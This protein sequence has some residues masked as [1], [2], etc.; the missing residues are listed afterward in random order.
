V[1]AAV[2]Y[3]SRTGN[4]KRLAQAIADAQKMPLIDIASTLPSTVEKYDLL[5]LGTP[6]E[7]AS[8]AKETVAFLEG[9]NLHGGGKAIFFCTW[10]LFCN[11]RT[12]KA[13]EKTLS[14]KGYTTILRVSKKG[15]KPDKEADFSD[16]LNEI[17][18]ALQ[19]L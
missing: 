17:Q 13:M 15:M 9:M 6:V 8:P 18:K 16:V 12:M 19:K 10:K 3:F 2:V 4:T 5:I 11:E 14:A 7:G 1:N